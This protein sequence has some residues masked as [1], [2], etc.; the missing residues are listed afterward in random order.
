MVNS[1]EVEYLILIQNID[2]ESKSL[3]LRVADRVGGQVDSYRIV[4][5]SLN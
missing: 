3:P 4:Q 5:S 2:P 1:G